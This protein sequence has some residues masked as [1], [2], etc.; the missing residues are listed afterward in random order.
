M[1]NK[2]RFKKLLKNSYPF[3]KAPEWIV[4]DAGEPEIG[5]QI[6]SYDRLASFHHNFR[7]RVEDEEQDLKDYKRAAEGIYGPEFDSVEDQINHFFLKKG[8]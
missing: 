6:T 3:L 2:K 5:N 1:S 8:K 4:Q 7:G